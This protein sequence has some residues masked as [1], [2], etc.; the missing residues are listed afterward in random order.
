MAEPRPLR[1]PDQTPDRTP[2]GSPE[3]TPDPLGADLPEAT[4]GYKPPVPKTLQ[5]LHELDQ[6]DESLTKYKKSLLGDARGSHGGPGGLWVWGYEGLGSVG[7]WWV[8]V[9]VGL[10]VCGHRVLWR[11]S[12]TVCC[13]GVTC[14]VRVRCVR[15]GCYV[16]CACALCA[17]C[18]C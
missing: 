8:C 4:P 7:S 6:D 13:A 3:G 15:G 9:C 12:G 2:E 17:W 5:E 11:T 14:V 18:G 16:R 1:T 10:W